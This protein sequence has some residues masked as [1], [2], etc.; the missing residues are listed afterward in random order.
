LAALDGVSTAT[1]ATTRPMRAGERDGVEYHFLDR[2]T[3]ERRL[4]HGDF[5]EHAEYAG[6]LYGTPLD[7]VE[8]RLGRGESV[9]LEIELQ[10]ARA[11]R[12]S[13]P[14]ALAVFIAPPSLDE[15]E[16]RLEG[17]GTEGERAIH[18]RLEVAE[19]ELA[20]RGE[21]DYLVIND[22]VE[23]ASAE[24]VEVILEETTARPTEEATGG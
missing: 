17:R 12:A 24:L 9:I 15:L 5:L 1:S 21:F 20:A 19:R 14:D 23:R 4:A 11:V 16:R 6:N 2:A 13:L 7:E 8:R 22:N 3:F 10:G 18:A